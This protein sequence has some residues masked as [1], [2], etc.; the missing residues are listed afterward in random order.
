MYLDES[1]TYK[2]YE[3]G[4]VEVT[5]KEMGVAGWLKGPEKKR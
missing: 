2:S 1:G 5:V 4:P 3:P